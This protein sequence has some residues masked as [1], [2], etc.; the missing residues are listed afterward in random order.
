IDELQDAVDV[1][2]TMTPVGV[3]KNQDQTLTIQAETQLSNADQFANL[4]I[5]TPNN[6]PVRLGDVAKVI[7]SVENNQTASWFQGSRSIVM[8]IQRQPDANTVEV[9]DRVKNMLPQ[10]RDDVPPT[11]SISLLSDRSTSIR[12]AVHDVELTLMLSIALVIMVTFL[13]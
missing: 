13:F 6:K 9:V 5:A 3:I 11:V 7:D 12:D 2:N 10:F 4:I 8:A 1:A